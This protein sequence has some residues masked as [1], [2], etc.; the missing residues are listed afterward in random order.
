M[1]AQEWECLAIKKIGDDVSGTF[2]FNASGMPDSDR[3]GG[4]AQFSD[5]FNFYT[6]DQAKADAN[7]VT[8]NTNRLRVNVIDDDLDWIP[9]TSGAN[10]NAIIFDLWSHG[11][12]PSDTNWTLRLKVVATNFVQ[13][14][15]PNNLNFDIILSDSDQSVGH[16]A[17][18]SFLHVL[19]HLYTLYRLNEYLRF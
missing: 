18:Q 3:F 4:F 19:A 8:S 5:N 14:T 1:S 17:N 10:D 11:I 9:D 2:E 6:G 12:F 7:W 16:L 13:G 15:S